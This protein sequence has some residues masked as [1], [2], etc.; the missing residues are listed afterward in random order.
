MIMNQNVSTI[1]KQLLSSEK[2]IHIKLLGD[3]I[4]HGVGGTGFVQDGEPIVANFARNPNGYCWAKLLKDYL[5]SNYDCMVNNNGCTG[6]R[7][8]FV[9][10]HFDTLVSEE[11]NLVICMIGTNNRHQRYDEP[12]MR[13]PDEQRSRFYE[14]IKV[15]YQKFLDAGKQ[16]IFMAN[17]P[18]SEANE[19]DG[20]E[21]KR[22]IHMVDI[23]AL[24]EKA[25]LE[26]GFPM[27]SLYRR[28]SEY[29]DQNKIEL[30]TLLADGLHP[31]DR[32]Y[33]VMYH[34]LKKEFGV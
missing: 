32:G 2:T 29:C 33:D 8:E 5:E 27:V 1:F 17:I 30:D 24:Y 6:T 12:P 14:N 19:Q 7:I 9:I 18:A 15:L 21:Y 34:L 10:E 26:F 31:N 25:S 20:A 23:N 16:V 4:T 3:S 11:D 13:T 28:F 22:L